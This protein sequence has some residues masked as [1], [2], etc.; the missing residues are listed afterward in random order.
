MHTTVHHKILSSHVLSA[1]LANCIYICN[2]YAIASSLP[3]KRN[4][5][6]KSEHCSIHSYSLYH[7]H[8]AYEILDMGSIHT[9]LVHYNSN[10]HTLDELCSNHYDKV[11][12]PCCLV[13]IVPVK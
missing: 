4:Q 6:Q 13:I 3:H 5:Y 1:T 8:W 10:C 7:V 9:L 12:T 2:K 11:T